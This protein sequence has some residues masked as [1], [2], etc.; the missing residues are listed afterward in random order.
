MQHA[1]AQHDSL[2]R[3]AINSHRGS[4]FKT[5]GDAFCA[6]FDTAPEALAAAVTSQRTL[7]AEN[8]GETPIR[9]R[10]ALHTG[11][12]EERNEDYFG[13]DVNRVARLLSAGHGGQILLSG[14]T[15]QLVRKQLPHD[16]EIRDLGHHR[17]KDLSFPE[18]IYQVVAHGLQ[19]EFSPL[20]T[21]KTRPTNLPAQTTLFVGR[22][23]ELADL[24]Q[25]LANPSL[26]L[27]TILGQGGIG[28][29]HLALEAAK[30]RIDHCKNGVFFVSLVE[31]NSEPGIIYALADSIGF[32]F[33]SSDNP[34]QQLLDYLHGKEMLIV[35]DNF[36]HL[37]DGVGIV[38]DIVQIAPHVTILATSREK[39]NL[40]EEV[41]FRI[42]GLDYSHRDSV[43]DALRSDAFQL[44]LLRAQRAQPGFEPQLEDLEQIANI[45]LLVDGLPLGILLAAA[46]IEMLTPKEIADEI[47]DSLDFLRSDLRNIPG[48]HRSIRVVISSTWRQLSES[49]RE[50]FA[51]LSVFR[52][53]F[54]LEA[55]Q[56]VTTASLHQLMVLSN[57]SLIHRDHGGRFQIHQLPLQ[58]AKEKLEE[59]PGIDWN[60]HA[61]HSQYYAELVS[62]LREDLSAEKTAQIND[63]FNKELQ[64]IRAGWRWAA[65]WGDLQAVAKYCD[66]L[67]LFFEGRGWYLGGSKDAATYELALNRLCAD[68]IETEQWQRTFCRLHEIL[69]DI[70]ALAN[71]CDDAL[72]HFNA[73]LTNLPDVELIWLARLHRKNANTYR[74]HKQFD[75]AFDS[76]TA[77]EAALGSPSNRNAIWWKEWIQIQLERTW[78]NYWQGALDTVTQLKV[79]VSP[80]VEQFGT[81]AQQVNFFNV[82]GAMS[83]RRER[84]FSSEES[85]TP[86]QIAYTKSLESGN[87]NDIAWS[88]FTYGF[89]LLWYGD[90]DRSEELIQAALSLAQAHGDFV[91]Q[92]RCLTY[93]TIIYRK[94]GDIELVRRFADASLEMAGKADM[95]EYI[96][97]AQANQAWLAWYDGNLVNA[98]V[99]G[100]QALETWDRVGSQ[101]AST[102]FRW[103][104]IWPLMGLAMEKK[105]IGAAIAYAQQLLEPAQQRLPD[106]LTAVLESA[107]ESWANNRPD[108]SCK[109]LSAALGQSDLKPQPTN[110]SLE[111]ERETI[112]VPMSGNLV[113]AIES[114]TPREFE[115]LQLI[116]AGLSNQE[117]AEQLVI[118]VSTVK[119]HINHLFG[120]LAVDSR[121][122]AV[123][124]AREL[125]LI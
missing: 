118:E 117:I 68:R 107:I 83:W 62:Q 113:G 79:E 46:W 98:A 3:Q 93:L 30:S 1:L 4:I 15:Q 54:K 31:V 7:L 49:E 124:R 92:A 80:K 99:K 122:R 35:L 44:F 120:K 119:K 26:R 23:K 40:N 51:S 56:R 75:E 82:L 91:H 112:G 76:Y 10:M 36:E 38:S 33:R 123:V 18:H 59:D 21:P 39:L 87:P 12:A 70:S 115:V 69:G 106:K 86:T 61:Q 72:Q 125:E 19:Q 77:A 90:L 85:L 27:I 22:K 32:Q 102:A 11:V 114:L 109:W 55:A 96:G 100:N 97:T 20:V 67:W 29:T 25:M 63:M 78:L 2:I 73:A 71:Q 105:Q 37:L 17:L 41:L 6:A 121:T 47:T 89:G 16:V 108:E 116:S 45:C 24:S 65:E 74:N 60:A 88:Q 81:L 58:F 66:G 13:P 28:K 103:T 95:L 64:N 101:Y 34:D 52:G 53:G 111:D 57:K 94:R 50:I 14:A 8:W 110:I 84:Y 48:R 42:E 5:V 9:V 43:E 104:A